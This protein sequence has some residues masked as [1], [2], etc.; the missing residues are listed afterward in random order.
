MWESQ[1]SGISLGNGRWGTGGDTDREFHKGEMTCTHHTLEHRLDN[2]HTTSTSLSFSNPTL[3]L[4]LPSGPRRRVGH[5]RGLRRLSTFI[6]PLQWTDLT[7]VVWCN[8]LPA[9]SHHLELLNYSITQL[10]SP[11]L[12]GSCTKSLIKVQDISR[13]YPKIPGPHFRSHSCQ[14]ARILVSS[15]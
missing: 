13:R 8:G 10:L 11:L 1:V 3:P 2:P 4:S 5:M 9:P 7:D 14:R 15:P 12:Q 6:F